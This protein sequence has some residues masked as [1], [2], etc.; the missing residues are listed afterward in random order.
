MEKKYLHRFILGCFLLQLWGC[1]TPYEPEIKEDV[2]GILVVEGFIQEQYN[3]IVKLSKAKPISSKLQTEAVEGTIVILCDDG[4]RYSMEPMKEKGEIV[5]GSYV[6]ASPVTFDMNAKYALHI[7]TG[8]K[9]YQSEFVAPVKTP[10]IDEVTWI[11]DK[12]NEQVEIFVSTHDPANR[13]SCY[14]W[15]Y[16][17]D[18]E[19]ISNL[20]ADFWY[21][22][23]RNE[24]VQI[25]LWEPNNIYHC[26]KSARSNK[27]IIGNAED[28]VDYT[29]KDQRV[30][31]IDVY[32]N[33]DRFNY[34]YGFNVKQYGLTTEAYT[35]YK[36][37]ETNLEETGSLFAAQPTELEGNITCISD[38]KEVAIGYI[39][40]ATESTMRIFIPAENLETITTA[41]EDCDDAVEMGIGF[42]DYEGM[43]RAY[44][45]EYRV[46][47]IDKG[48]YRW[49]PARCIDCTFRGGSKNKPDFWP[50]DHV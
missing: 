7:T 31:K 16:D 24:V 20:Y 42:T 35:Y 25:N 9:E 12:E 28:L 3:T 46:R 44:K 15:M 41:F 26:W 48:G 49:S 23:I 4:T 40:A 27:L 38:P 22:P 14:Q 47:M 39:A 13:I 6:A 30:A 29:I 11:E 45:N 43:A 36:N 18:W 21:D 10:P 50:N 17:E 19:H 2:S 8:G 5:P 37:L 33:D 34:L 32:E 1:I